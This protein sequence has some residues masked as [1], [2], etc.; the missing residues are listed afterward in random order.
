LELDPD[1]IKQALKDG[2]KDKSTN[3]YIIYPSEINDDPKYSSYSP[4]EF[5]FGQYSD[6]IDEKIYLHPDGKSPFT[7][8]VRLKLLYSLLEA[9]KNK[10]G[11]FIEF[12]KLKYTGKIN[13]IFPLHD[14]TITDQMVEYVWEWQCTPWNMPFEDYRQYFGEKMSLYYLF[15]AHYSRWLIIP[16]IVG[17]SFQLVVW[18]TL[19]FSHPVLPF[20]GVVICLWSIFMLEY[21]KQEQSIKAVHWGMT[22]FEEDEPDR[23]EFLGEPI[24]SY[25]DGNT[26]LYYPVEHQKDSLRVSYAVISSFIMLLVGVLAS[27]YIL[28]FALQSGAAAPYA[29]TI[30]SV[31][32]TIQ[33]TVFNSIYQEVATLL[34]NNENHRT[35]T[36]YEDYLIVKL[37][38]F[39]FINS[40]SSFFFLAFIA[41]SLPR[42]NVDDDA[43]VGECGAPSCMNPL[44]INLAIIFG[45]RL[46]LNNFMQI[47]FPYRNYKK[48][49]SEE[50]ADVDPET[51]LHMTPAECDYLLMNYDGLLENINLYA[52]AAIQYGFSTLFVT[53]LP[54]APA[55]SLISNYFKCKL[56]IWKTVKFYQRPMPIG[57]QDIGTWLYIFQFLSAAA[58][59]TNGALICFTMK[60]MT[61]YSYA[62]KAWIFIGF[63]WTLFTAQYLS[64]LFIDDVPEDVTI[65]IQRMK[66]I[67]EKVI[68]KVPDPEGEDG[69]EHSSNNV[70]TE[71]PSTCFTPGGKYMVRAINFAGLPD[72]SIQPYPSKSTYNF[73]NT[74]PLVNKI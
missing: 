32:N 1:A 26:F 53:A 45:T 56:N 46:T 59:I 71:H 72:V 18:G 30:A 74:N 70:V 13:S 36:L 69:D 11:C 41:E 4:Y 28:K 31:L 16:S 17:F 2:Y 25:I 51:I 12:S 42:P 14:R 6:D 7:K 5:I 34:T 24:K 39:Q 40:Y 65:Q 67:E 37:F 9:P 66:Y 3:R 19:N 8:L 21:W 55:L 33:I 29:S 52:D 57:A 43:N 54:V 44:S 62:G 23:P 48:K 68:F 60:I 35:D 27:I 64:M 50:T 73:S 10:N 22:E 20:F 47:F 61:H 58:V 49:F 15:M 63:Q 38:A